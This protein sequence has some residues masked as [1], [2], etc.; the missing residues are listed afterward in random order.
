MNSMEEIKKNPEVLIVDDSVINIKILSKVLKNEGFEIRAALNGKL[1]LELIE[2]KRPEVIL[3]D[4][5]LGDINGY[6]ICKSLKKNEETMN[7]PVIFISAYNS[8]EDI[9]KGFEAGGVDYIKKPFNNSEIAARVKTHYTIGKL[10]KE[11]QEEKE[12]LSNALSRN[13]LETV[14]INKELKKEKE[15]TEY[16]LENAKVMFIIINKNREIT[17]INTEGCCILEYEKN[18]I[19]GKDILNFINKEKIINVEGILA[20]ILKEDLIGI[21]GIEFEIKNKSGEV[22]IIE[23]N[24]SLI[25]GEKESVEGLIISG[26]DRTNERILEGE[27]T[28]IM[29]DMKNR[30]REIE[31]L[32]KIAMFSQS[33]RELD[34]KFVDTIVTGLKTSK[35][36][37]VKI[38]L[39]DKEYKSSSC[40]E[41]EKNISRLLCFNNKNIGKIDIFFD[42]EKITKEELEI[43]DEKESDFLEILYKM[44]EN[45]IAGKMLE[46]E[47]INNNIQLKET[48]RIAKL[49][50]WRYD[51]KQ[52][53]ISWSDET[54]NIFGIS[55]RKNV[56]FRKYMGKIYQEINGVDIENFEEINKINEYENKIIELKKDDGSICYVMINAK[57]VYKNGEPVYIM[58]SIIDITELKQIQKNLEKAMDAAESSNRAK[59]FFISNMSHEIRTPLNA[60]IGFSQLLS[61]SSSCSGEEREQLNIIIKSGE[62]L[63]EIINNILELSKIET[64]KVKLESEVFNIKNVISD[65]VNMFSKQKAEKGI[66]ISFDI[67]GNNN[68]Y[69]LGDEKKIRQI[70]INLIGNAVKFT[71]KGN[72]EIG[73]KI[74]RE[75]DN[76]IKIESFVKDT[77]IGMPESYI[78]KAFLRFEQAENNDSR[79]GGTGLGLAITKE[80]IELMNG[81]IKVKSKVNEGSIFNFYF[82]V[83]GTEE[84]GKKVNSK[85]L[86]RKNTRKKIRAL[87]VDDIK[88]NIL[89]LREIMKLVE[90]DTDY[91]ENG[92]KAIEKVKKEKYDIIFMDIFMPVMDG[93]LAIQEIRKINK[94]IIIIA[95]TAS[96]FE[97][98]KKE[99]MR[100]DIDEFIG[101]PFKE[102]EIYDILKRKL[103]ISYKYESEIEIEKKLKQNK[104]INNEYILEKIP[105][106]IVEKMKDDIIN[107]DID[108]IKENIEKI[109]SYD[110]FIADEIKTM[111]ENYQFEKLNE[112]FCIH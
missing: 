11:L 112:I 74:K 40:K 52:E 93:V 49:G 87:I 17:Y 31:C 3:L 79:K 51:V 92:Q 73:V 36:P 44:L 97:E 91:A 82:F 90:I 43:V 19:I 54:Y 13:N 29:N 62:H 47:L 104:I 64:G 80:F 30:I 42:N 78:D 20:G 14:I 61:R 99:V 7:I 21:N 63:L 50:T 5:R 72:I 23:C 58:G 111:A 71:E 89:L 34:S 56:N 48:Q 94:E 83:N 103:K 25:N 102:E 98:E 26:H 10:T 65:V 59:T 81:N 8:E 41:S 9:I 1:G 75:R 12:K 101:K 32:Y 108:G 69:Y 45:I 68:L 95:V 38:T 2:K 6:E 67:A 22:R 105:K 109:K 53:K 46:E 84:K 70:Y 55:D 60:I 96:V 35:K 86:A 85:I 27:R 88:E 100:Y 24:I 107:G 28:Q 37:S 4:V 76:R 106:E 39:K 33:G 66:N 77:G 16:Y 18:E 110:K 15:K 57:I